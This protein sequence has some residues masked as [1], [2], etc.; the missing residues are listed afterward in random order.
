MVSLALC[1]DSFCVWAITWVMAS[2]LGK[3]L[4]DFCCHVL[5]C[6]LGLCVLDT[7]CDWTGQ[8]SH[9]RSPQGEKPQVGGNHIL[10]VG[11]HWPRAESVL[12]NLGSES[13]SGNAWARI[14]LPVS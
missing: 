6:P 9:S 13:L 1:Q 8:G 4:L 2:G 7:L 14:C 11:R 10:G 3:D 5:K 12:Q